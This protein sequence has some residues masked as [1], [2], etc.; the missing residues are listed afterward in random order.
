VSLHQFIPPEALER[1]SRPTGE[2]GT[3]LPNACYTS[4]EWLELE[5]ERLFAR[6]WMFA[7][8]ID[9]IPEPGDVFPTTIGNKPVILV[10]GRD[11]EIRAFHNVCRHRGALV[12]NEPCS[13]QSVLTCPYHAW[14]Y[15]LDGKLRSRPHFNGAGSHDLTK[16]GPGLTPI[17][18]G[19]FHRT[20]FL[21]LDG[22]A[23]PFEDYI[24]PLARRLAGH[25][26]SALRLAKTL[27]WEFKANWKL[28]FENYFDNYHIFA[29]HPRLDAFAP[30]T[31]R[32]AFEFEN[33]L[34]H[35]EVE[36]GEPEEGRGVGL[37]YYPGLTPELERFEGGYHLFPSCCFQIWPDQLTVF[38]V[39]PVA[40]D[41][42]IEHLHVFVMGD[43]A[44]DPA[45]EAARQGVY[46]M[47]D[48]LNR[49]DIDAIE[50][51]QKGRHSPAFDGGILSGFWDPQHQH[52]AKLV[53]ETMA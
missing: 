53:V 34:F 38:Q 6:T 26:L 52:F 44:T 39:F 7:G 41:H 17:R 31:A 21:N 27:V 9:H 13:N 45:Y 2:G 4:P 18:L 29:I 12:V 36:F 15:G 11:G 35:T 1:I 19:L 48:E 8:S 40:P 10:H 20:I 47:W 33:R 22:R 46:D 50:W 24:A 25:D 30:I 51:M 16:Q 28:V 37:P 42:T 3:C 43:A 5:N 14:A 23:E 49:E 32:K